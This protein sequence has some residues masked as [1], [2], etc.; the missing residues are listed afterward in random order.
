MK[1]NCVLLL[2][3][4]MLLASCST[5][6]PQNTN[7]LCEI[8]S[9][10]RRWYRHTAASVKRWGG[11]IPTIMAF[12]HQESS[13][14]AKAKPRRRRLLWVIPW[15][16]LSS[17][18]G[19]AQA[20]EGTWELY[21]RESGNKNAKRKSFKHAVDFVAW[22][23][24]RS[25]RISAITAVPEQ[26]VRHL[27]LAYH[28]GWKGYQSNK[29]RGKLPLMR[30]AQ[31]VENRAQRYRTQLQRCEKRLKRGPWWWPF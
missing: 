13:F 4:G 29:W 3:F 16:R 11:D 26:Q 24:W 8:F 27:Y 23:N 21:K 12:L 22:Y 20:L 9:E 31:L 15:K 28:E 7:D 14:R 30:T 25:R 6:P 2:L 10:K 5:A 1:R 19:Y 17:A 18:E